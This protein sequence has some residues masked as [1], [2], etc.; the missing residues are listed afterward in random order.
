[1]VDITEVVDKD[2]IEEANFL[3]KQVLEMDRDEL[4]AIINWLCDENEV[5]EERYYESEKSKADL[6]GELA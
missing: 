3:G 5:L 1:M 6:M 2:D 4:L